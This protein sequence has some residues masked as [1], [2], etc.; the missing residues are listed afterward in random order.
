MFRTHSS[1]A[2]LVKG[3]SNMA[4]PTSWLDRWSRRRADPTET[5]RLWIRRSRSR[6][7][8]AELNDHDLADIG[9]SRA[10]AHFESERP[11][12]RP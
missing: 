10:Q 12:W 8:L 7:S 5:L 6:R 11:F 3:Q 9:L 4:A 1:T 2:A